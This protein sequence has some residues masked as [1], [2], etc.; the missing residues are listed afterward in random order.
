MFPLTDCLQAASRLS[1]GRTKKGQILPVTFA[2]GMLLLELMLVLYKEGYRG[3]PC[4][5]LISEA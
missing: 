1:R 4:A 3:C 2:Y 5:H